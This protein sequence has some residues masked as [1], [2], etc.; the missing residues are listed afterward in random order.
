MTT[1]Q[2]LLKEIMD[3]YTEARDKWIALYGND[4]H[5]NE[6]FSTQIKK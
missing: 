4:N 2:Q 1:Q 5:F 3:K 6:W